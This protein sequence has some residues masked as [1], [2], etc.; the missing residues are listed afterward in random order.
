MASRS[1]ATVPCP[2][3][4]N[5]SLTD[6]QSLCQSLLKTWSD[7]IPVIVNRATNCPNAPLIDKHKYLVPHNMSV[8][9]FMQTVIQRRL[10]A[11]NSSKSLFLSVGTHQLSTLSQPIAQVYERHKANDGFLYLEYRSENMF[12]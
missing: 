11:G 2:F 1:P 3:T 7:R 5:K 9:T 10:F 6:R 4:E 12:G 8:G